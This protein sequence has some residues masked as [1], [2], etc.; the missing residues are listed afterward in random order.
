MPMSLNLG[1]GGSRATGSVL[2]GAASRHR[3][4]GPCLL[5]CAGGL[6]STSATKDA[7][8]RR[9]GAPE[10]LSKES[11]A[12]A[13]QEQIASK[14]VQKATQDIQALPSVA[15]VGLPLERLM[16]QRACKERQEKQSYASALR[17]QIQARE[18]QR[19]ADDKASRADAFSSATPRH[20]RGGVEAPLLGCH[21]RHGAPPLPSKE[22]YAKALHEQIRARA[23]QQ[24]VEASAVEEHTV[25]DKSAADE[26]FGRGRRHG[27]PPALPKSQYAAELQQQIAARKAQGPADAGPAF[28]C[29][30]RQ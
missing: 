2:P 19:A 27:A 14:K 30:W 10:K 20:A 3:S 22:N 4:A 7:K 29:S 16:E 21:R 17:A 6:L 1:L 13:L 9:Y 15:E 12:S 24:A 8:M 28:G 25:W 11:Y 5:A 23:A 26:L 18:S